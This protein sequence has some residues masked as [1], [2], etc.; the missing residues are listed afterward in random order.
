[1]TIGASWF[2][3]DFVQSS[4]VR[5]RN[6]TYHVS[7][8][9]Y[10]RLKTAI[11]QKDAEHEITLL[12]EFLCARAETQLIKPPTAKWFPE[13]CILCTYTH[14][15]THTHTQHTHT[16]THRGNNLYQGQQYL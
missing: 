13:V 11:T 15:H 6:S 5:D 8:A 14:T 12:G 2:D 16:H 4:K 1:V 9:S 10:E 3:S 7:A